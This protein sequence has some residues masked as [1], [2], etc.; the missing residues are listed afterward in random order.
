M[1]AK[2]KIERMPVVNPNAAGIDVGGSFHY[3]GIGQRKEDV[4]KYGVYTTELHSLAKWLLSE[5]IT[6]VAMESTGDYWRS[7]YIILQDYGIEVIL[8][9]GKYTKNVKPN[10]FPKPMAMSE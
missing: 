4:K 6:T 2:D 1:A 9:N 3:V 10:I 7:L 8:V 5:G